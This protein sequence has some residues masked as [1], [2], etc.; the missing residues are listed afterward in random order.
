M[1]VNIIVVVLFAA[2]LHATW[3]FLVKHSV[4][5]YQ[6]MTSVVLGRVPFGLAVLFLVPSISSSSL[7]Y[8]V[9]GA[10]LHTGY[11]LFLLNSYRFGDLSQVYPMARGGAPLIVASISLLF[12]GVS[13][14]ALELV[15]LIIIGGGIVSLAFAGNKSST[16][17]R[18]TSAILAI[19]TGF[20]I[21]GYS[22]VDGLGA[23]EAGT[24][25][26]YYGLVTVI[27]AVIYGIVVSRIR[28]GLVTE[29]ARSNLPTSLLSGGCSYLAYALIVW[30]FTKA[31]IALVA[32]LRETSIIFALLFGLLFLKERLSVLKA[33]AI[34]FTVVGVGLLKL[35]TYL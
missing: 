22:L 26:G 13:Y 20:F 32:S 15:A 12:L 31:P 23:R 6:G 9:I 34:L 5:A 3:N 27:N 21:A 11:Q 35:S 7:V 24:A 4:D 19:I 28:P 10:I 25:L 17:N 29:V 30:A 2:L 18:Y 33:I 8:V 16:E 14:D 1:S